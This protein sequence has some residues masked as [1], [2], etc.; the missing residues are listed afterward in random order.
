MGGTFTIDGTEIDISSIS[1]R[2]KDCL[3]RLRFVESRI[4]EVKNMHA[5]LIRSK[6]NYIDS[7]EREIV[8]AR[9]GVELSTFI[10]D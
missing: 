8:A 9:S 6:R 2:G 7:L 4:A 10:S 5:L 3:V 1:D